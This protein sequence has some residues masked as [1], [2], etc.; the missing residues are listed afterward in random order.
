LLVTPNQVLKSL[1][2]KILSKR[3]AED[4]LS[5]AKL[6]EE[7]RPDKYSKVSKEDQLK[8]VQCMI[9][10]KKSAKSML[11]R[12]PE[13]PLSI[14]TIGNWKRSYLDLQKK[15]QQ[16]DKKKFTE[17]A[18]ES[19]LK[20]I[21]KGRPSLDQTDLLLFEKPMEEYYQYCQAVLISNGKSNT[22]HENGGTLELS[23]RWGVEEKPQRLEN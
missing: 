23:P 13:L 14:S 8:V 2:T 9:A 18:T 16:T 12:F 15:F 20:G 17:L 3:K 1:D 11:S 22:L 4:V 21:K 6:V 5:N 10:T 19:F 7:G